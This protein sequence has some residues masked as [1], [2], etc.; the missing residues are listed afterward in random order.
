MAK[1]ERVIATARFMSDHVR[2][3]YGVDP[4]IVRVIHR[5]IDLDRFDPQQV[6]AGRVVQLATEW[7]LPD[8]IPIVLL[9]GRLT[10]WKGQAVLIE[11]LARHGHDRVRCLLVGDEQG[12]TGYRR[13]LESLIAP[14]ERQS[15]RLNSRH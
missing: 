15:T 13:E 12:R 4:R 6:T 10:R 14:R 9:P 11:A 2:R 3:D 7:R 8:G 1:G 5:G